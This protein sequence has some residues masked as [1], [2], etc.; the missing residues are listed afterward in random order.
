MEKKK[1]GY[2]ANRVQKKRNGKKGC[3]GHPSAHGIA[4]LRVTCE[5]A[6]EPAPARLLASACGGRAVLRVLARYG[7][8][9]SYLAD[10][11]EA[12]ACVCGSFGEVYIAFAEDRGL[13]HCFAAF[14]RRVDPEAYAPAGFLLQRLNA[15][16]E[17]GSFYLD[18]ALGCVAYADWYDM[19]AGGADDFTGFCLGA[20]LAFGLYGERLA[21]IPG[22][23]LED[24]PW[25]E[26]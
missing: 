20:C 4:H 19:Q 3:H 18:D 6:G 24:G 22:R 7:I 11:Q 13:L 9:G 14:A 15:T 25:D 23:N 21:G 1:K 17:R 12:L 5:Q 26:T 8:R 2:T 10:R 16:L